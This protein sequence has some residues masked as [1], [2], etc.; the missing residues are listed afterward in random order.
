MQDLF[1]DTS[2]VK[3]FIPPM[4][5]SYKELYTWLRSTG[6]LVVSTKLK[7]EYIRGLSG[8]QGDSIIVLIDFLTRKGR[9][10]EINSDRIKNFKIKKG[11]KR[12]MRS[13]VEDHHHIITILLSNRK[14]AVSADANFRHDVNLQPTIDGI[15]PFASH[16]PSKLTYK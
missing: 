9:L 16:S 13:N 1:L 8:H 12:R 2:I 10:N 7:I 5:P 4:Q 11:I 3:H 6:T 14:L 15:K